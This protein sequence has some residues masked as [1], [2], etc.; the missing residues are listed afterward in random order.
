M[1]FLSTYIFIGLLAAGAFG[2]LEKK[3]GRLPK[4]KE[5]KVPF[6]GMLV[7]LLL[8]YPYYAIKGFKKSRTEAKDDII[9]AEVIDD[10]KGR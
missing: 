2:A 10:K 9:D 5:G 3:D 1:G 7:L 6:I 4:D 8:F